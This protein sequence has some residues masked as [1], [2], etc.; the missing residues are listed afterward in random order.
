VHIKIYKQL[1]ARSSLECAAVPHVG[2]RHAKLNYPPSGVRL[3]LFNLI[4]K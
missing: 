3:N 4:P 2:E 1:Q